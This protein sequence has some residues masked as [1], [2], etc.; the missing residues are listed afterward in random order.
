MRRLFRHEA[1]L[2]LVALLLGML[3][4]CMRAGAFGVR[5][6]FPIHLPQGSGKPPPI[7]GE[8]HATGGI[9]AS[10]F[11]WIPWIVVGVT[12]VALLLLG[13]WLLRNWREL[14]AS[15]AALV[16]TQPIEDGS[17][18]DRLF[19]LADASLVDPR[20]PRQGVIRCWEQLEIAAALLGE[21]R[22]PSETSTD[23]TR[24]VL[25]SRFQPSAAVDDLHRRF[26]GA[27][28]SDDEIGE[29]ERAAARDDLAALLGGVCI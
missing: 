18:V 29:Q 6:E 24:R 20:D 10:A 5:F 13:I 17:A 1:A 23:F 11:D 19:A 21:S 2:L 16:V 8:K 26:L 15:E 14:F 25:A 7:L 12:G 3:A 22:R 4:L 28:F 27:R 9:G